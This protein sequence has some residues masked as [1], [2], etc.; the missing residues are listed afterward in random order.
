MKIYKD[1]GLQLIGFEELQKDLAAAVEE[2]PVIAKEEMRKVRNKF[3]RDIR[4][5]VKSQVD[6]D[7]NL[8][9]G[10]S[11]PISGK[12]IDLK[13]EFSGEKHGKNPHWHLIEDGHVIVMPYTTRDQY[14]RK[15]N[16]SDG[17]RTKG[18]VPGIQ[19]VKKESEE[20]VPHLEAAM[21]RVRDKS[22][23]GHNL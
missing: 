3:L 7:D 17:G 18:F 15:V 12:G 6:S 10:F 19:A 13:A 1:S 16:R 21:K 9:S 20:I 4:K 14:G 5:D 22:L 23:E 11:M 8:T 2:A